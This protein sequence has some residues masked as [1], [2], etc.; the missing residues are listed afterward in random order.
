MGTDNARLKFSFHMTN[1]FMGIHVRKSR[2]SV[3]TTFRIFRRASGLRSFA[4]AAC[5]LVLGCATASFAEFSIVTAREG[6]TFSSLSAQY[7]ND[8]SWGPLIAEYNETESLKPG[9]L[10]LIPSKIEKRGGLD[11]RGYQTVPV[12]SYHNFSL[13]E[14][15]RMTVSR[16]M[17]EEQMRLLKEKEYRVVSVDRFFDFLEFKAPLPPRSVLIT[18]DD[19]RRSAY[20]IAFPALKQHG[21]P[22]TLFIYTDS[23]LEKRGKL[24][25]DQLREMSREGMEI[26]CHAKSHASL[27]HQGK[28]QTFREYFANLERELSLSKDLIHKQLNREVKYLAYPFGDCS[29]LVIEMARKLGYRGA[30]TAA[31]GGNP[32]FAH[33]YRIN[34]SMIFGDYTLAQ[35][36]KN[37][38]T[39]QEDSLR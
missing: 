38:T 20:D 25:W 15:S 36:E 34:R 31:R 26:Q 5:L 28:K 27:T 35:F 4:A 21:F 6:D 10:V 8:P 39:F 11:F 3:I 22:A 24:S 2:A 7:L 19:G 32:F 33:P 1:S 30:F 29:P 14:S 17:F 9:Q 37:L 12:L 13:K 16:P 23:L 18:I